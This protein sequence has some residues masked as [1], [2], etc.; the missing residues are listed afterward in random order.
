MR[1]HE[2]TNEQIEEWR[3]AR[4]KIGEKR[5]EDTHL[6]RYNLVDVMEEI[7]DALNILV[8]LSNRCFKQN[9]FLPQKAV[10]E[11]YSLTNMLDFTIQNVQMADKE[12][13][14]ELCTDEE[15]GER[16]WWNEYDSTET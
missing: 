8:R 2:L 14:D 5:Y 16:V 3:Q 4:M 6:G 9:R 10:S 15:G 1:L 11:L 7:L 13:P 12:I